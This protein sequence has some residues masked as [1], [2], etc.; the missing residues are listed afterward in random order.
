MAPSQLLPTGLVTWLISRLHCP[1][2]LLKLECPKTATISRLQSWTFPQVVKMLFT[3]TPKSADSQWP[4]AWRGRAR[5]DSVSFSWFSSNTFHKYSKL[6]WQG[7][8]TS[9]AVLNPRPSGQSYEN[10]PM[11]LILQ[12]PYLMSNKNGHNNSSAL[13]VPF[14]TRFNPDVASQDHQHSFERQLELFAL[15]NVTGGQFKVS[16]ES[17]T[18]GGL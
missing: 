14:F 4:R 15:V 11:Y 5:L 6:D 9:A 12:N 3:E 2:Q 10:Q 18:N 8:E 17:I 16:L 7:H 1:E 13:S